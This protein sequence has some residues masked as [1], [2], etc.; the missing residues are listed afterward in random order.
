MLCETA[1]GSPY[2]HTCVLLISEPVYQGKD[3]EGMHT[4]EYLSVEA[5]MSQCLVQLLQKWRRRRKKTKN[6]KQLLRPGTVDYS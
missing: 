4:D 1:V 6:D 2:G 3:S 5:A